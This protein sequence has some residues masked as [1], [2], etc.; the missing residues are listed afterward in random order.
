MRRWKGT[1]KQKKGLTQGHV[2]VRPR[3]NDRG[4]GI[5]F[6]FENRLPFSKPFRILFPVAE[7]G[8]RPD[9]PKEE[10][11][12]CVRTIPS[13][14]FKAFFDIENVPFLVG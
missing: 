9:V 8:D 11:L 14:V 10:C 7:K 2:W 13:F 12:T 5:K 6:C 1:H 3:I 4:H